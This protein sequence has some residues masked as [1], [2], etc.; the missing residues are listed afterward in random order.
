MEQT[1]QLNNQNNLNYWP[2][3]GIAALIFGFISFIIS[4]AGGYLIINSES[5]GSMTFII[6]QSAIGIVSCLV[7]AFGGMLAVWHYARENQITMKLGK[8]A[9][10]GFLT[11]AAM[12]FV[13]IVLNQIWGLVDP[14]M[15][16]KMIDSLVANFEAMDMPE[17]QKQAMIDGTVQQMKNSVIN[18]LLWGIPI[19]GLLN[20]VTGMIGVALFARE[21]EV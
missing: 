10:I 16:Q 14:D 5:S 2:S 21:K 13:S 4:I 8:G 15:T 6:M 18:S 12:V 20:L 17:E 19:S 3:V 7:G 1:E 9:L 11:G